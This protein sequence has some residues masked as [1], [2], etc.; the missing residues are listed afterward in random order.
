MDSEARRAVATDLRERAED[1]L[2][3]VH[4]R[5]G[6]APRRDPLHFPA[7]P[8]DPDAF[9]SS[10]EEQLERIAGVAGA[11]VT[12]EDGRVLCVDVGYNDV[13]WQ[14]PG[15]A[16]EPGDSLVETAH[17]EVAEETGVEVELTGLLYTRIVEVDYGEPEVAPLP[18][19]VFTARKVG[20]SLR[21][22]TRTIPDGRD[23]IAD[24]SWFDP[25][26]LPAGTLDRD[27]IVE[28]CEGA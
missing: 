4:E 11:L 21:V 17:K 10:V 22:P 14:T 19:A 20:G 18:M 9:P 15:G 27:W 26:E 23:E 24:V 5:F 13:D 25:D 3:D 7:R 6:D 8:H 2:A 12:D 16:V 1:A 28:Y